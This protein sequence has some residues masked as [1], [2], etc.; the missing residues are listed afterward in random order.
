MK[1][2]RATGRFKL[3]KV[4]TVALKSDEDKPAD[5]GI[6]ADISLGGA[7]VITDV[8]LSVDAEV[9]L[10]LSRPH[11]STVSTTGKVRWIQPDSSGRVVRYGMR[12]EPGPLTDD[13]LQSLIAG[14]ATA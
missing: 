8:G 7:C 6:V 11:Y 4:M 2:T 1:E 10:A 12:F 9:G 3:V 5:F 13:L 14:N